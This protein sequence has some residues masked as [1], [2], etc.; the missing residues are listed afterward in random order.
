MN[1]YFLDKVDKIRSKIPEVP[2]CFTKCKE[3]MRGKRCK[4]S[5]SHVTVLKVN[6]L[7]KGLKNSKSVSFD[8][9]DSFSVKLAADILD[10]PLHHIITLSMMQNTFPVLWKSSKIIPVHK[11]DSRFDPKNYR[12]VSILSPLSKIAEKIVYEQMYKYFSNNKIFHSNM[13]GYRQNRSTCTALLSMY[14]RWVRAAATGN[15][16]GVVLLDLSAAFDLVEPNILIQKL[17]IYGLDDNCLD[18]IRTYLIG[19]QQAVWINHAQ[20]SFK[21]CSIGVPQ[22]SNLGPL[23]FSIFFNDLLYSLDCQ[24]ENFAD[25][26]TL[27]ASGQTVQEINTKLSSNCNAVSGWMRANKLKLNAEKTHLLAVGTKERL[28]KVTSRVQVVMDEVVIKEDKSRKD[29]LLLGC[30]ISADLKWNKQIAELKKRL[31]LRLNSLLYLQHIATLKTKKAIAE[32]IFHSVMLYCL[33]LFAGCERNNLKDL[34]VLQNCAARI[35]CKAH[36][37]TPR[38]ILFDQ[39]GWLSVNQMSVYYTLIMVYKIRESGQPEYLARFLKDDGR[40][41]RIRRCNTKLTLALQSFTFRGAQLW[42]TL[43]LSIRSSS[44]VR[45]FKLQARKWIEQNV[46]RFMEE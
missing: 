15:I 31:K 3:I 8:G 40:S 23:F 4:F 2:C 33:P 19:R 10:K 35:V 39:I 46:P 6:R 17:K 1:N 28:N 11:K 29:E 44:N 26:T 22:G 13:H 18:W 14:D 16:S 43:P 42:N 21:S 37:R 36:P 5:L 9:L 24:V 34:Q 7:L 27:S 30:Y 38:R 12:P 20:S 45:F 32:G 41:N 25:D